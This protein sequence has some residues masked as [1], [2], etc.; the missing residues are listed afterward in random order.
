MGIVTIDSCECNE[1]LFFKNRN[2]TDGVESVFSQDAEMELTPLSA[3]LWY[4]EKNGRVCLRLKT[5]AFP[6]RE[7]AIIFSLSSFG[8]RK[9]LPGKIGLPGAE[10]EIE[11]DAH[12]IGYT[13]R[14]NSLLL[15]MK[16]TLRFS[17]GKQEMKLTL[18]A[19]GK[20]NSEEK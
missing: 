20:R 13:L 2:L 16:Y 10:G 19:R 12:R 7:R 5:A 8:G 9:R 14:E 15:S 11:T 1:A 17:S 18:T 4:E 6:S 3:V